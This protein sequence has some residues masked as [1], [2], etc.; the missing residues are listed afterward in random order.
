MLS[1]ASAADRHKFG[2][3]NG[4]QIMKA[5][6]LSILGLFVARNRRDNDSPAGRSYCSCG[7]L[8]PAEERKSQT[9][10]KTG[11]PLQGVITAGK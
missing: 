6:L 8:M 7:A 11:R 3:W 10:M 9:S 5:A 4:D 1:V 2:G